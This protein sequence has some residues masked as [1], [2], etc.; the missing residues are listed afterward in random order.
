MGLG[1]RL[2][3]YVGVTHALKNVFTFLKNSIDGGPPLAIVIDAMK[4]IHP[5]AQFLVPS[6]RLDLLASGLPT[7]SWAEKKRE[8]IWVSGA[9]DRWTPDQTEAF[10]SAITL[11][12]DEG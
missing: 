2:H 6:L 7:A 3:R 8:N 1:Y 12:E 10:A 9:L 11:I 4:N 5:H